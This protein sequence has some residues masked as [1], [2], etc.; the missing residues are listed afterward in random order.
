MSY[1]VLIADDHEVICRGIQQVL[2]SQEDGFVVD[3]VSSGEA[4]LKLLRKDRWDALI[5]DLNLPGISGIE[6]LREARLI[7]PDLPVLIFSMH[8]PAQYA[9]RMLK[10]GAAGYLNKDE[11]ME[12][13]V[14]AL[15]QIKGG[16][17]FLTPSVAEALADHLMHAHPGVKHELLSNREFQVVCAIASGKTLNQIA[18]TLSLSP[19]TISTYR[20]RALD[21]LN[22]E[23]NSELIRYVLDH[24]LIPGSP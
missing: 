16:G 4:L 9:V 11:N 19:K 5:L 10:A 14:E 6:V 8:D 24:E 20:R 2:T 12:T 22:L 18:E 15:R 23:N 21:K 17:R 3:T 7:A 1:K 13:L